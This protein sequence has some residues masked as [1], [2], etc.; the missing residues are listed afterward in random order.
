MLGLVLMVSAVMPFCQ[1]GR[2][3]PAHSANLTLYHINPLNATGI[4]NM[5]LGNPEGDI[6]FDMTLVVQPFVCPSP[7]AGCDNREVL[8]PSIGLKKVVVELDTR[9]GYYGACNI[10]VNGSDPRNKS[11]SC[12]GDEYVCDCRDISAG[13]PAP[14]KECA[15][16]VGR[17]FPEDFFGVKGVGQFCKVAPP[18]QPGN[19][20]TGNAA[21]KMNGTW[22][23][24]MTLG[25]CTEKDDKPCAWRLIEVTKTVTRDCHLN[26]W[27]TAVEKEMEPGCLDKC[28][29]SGAGA[30]RNTSSKCW[31]QC[32][33]ETALGKGAGE[34]PLN[35]TG[36][37]SVQKL[38]DAWL[39]PFMSDDPSK[40][41]CP[42]VPK[43]GTFVV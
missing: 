11:R 28:T 21:G 43:T 14:N 17:E 20:W 37:M 23:S 41:G 39:A 32:W 33:F 6:F 38:K 7:F 31:V 8:G 24:P 29:D 34:W 2:P 10:C 42:D 30:A 22:Y 40:G 15:P 4:E 1:A 26:A 27:H 9:F 35:T 36:G 12:T 3:D 13:F 5:D 16:K 18:G 25:K 19:C